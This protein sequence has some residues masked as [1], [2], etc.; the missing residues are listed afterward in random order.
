MTV[1]AKAVTASAKKTKTFAKAKILTIKNAKG[2]V[3]F[4]KTKGDKKITI[5]TKTGK[6]T[7][8]KGLNKKTYKVSVTVKSAGNKTYKAK[9][10]KVTLTIKV[11]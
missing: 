11:K 5:N 3:T 8:K 1:K 4:K 7:V 2:T 9:S 10:K 6:L